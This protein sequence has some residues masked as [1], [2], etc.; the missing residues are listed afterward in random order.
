VADEHSK[1]GGPPEVL[2]TVMDDAARA[3][4]TRMK[5]FTGSAFVDPAAD[6]DGHL[7][8]DVLTSPTITVAQP[9]A[10]TDNSGSLT[11][12]GTVTA[13][14]A[15]GTNNIGDVD[16]ASVPATEAGYV[17]GKL[18]FGSISSSYATLVT[19]SGTGKIG[20]IFNAT[21]A[22]LIVSFDAS[23]THGYVPA[24]GTWDIPWQAAFLKESSNISIKHDGTAPTSGTV[25]G[26]VVT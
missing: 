22:D 20:V 13:N 16:V 7:Q 12:D 17:T 15:A 9:V 10:V 3:L 25:Y 8:V 5:A 4:R 2:R 23:T 19:M 6:A 18:A 1:S 24:R 11:V 21:N 14:L 26:N